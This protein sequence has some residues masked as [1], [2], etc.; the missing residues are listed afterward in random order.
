MT[1]VLVEHH[2]PQ[3]GAPAVLEETDR[4]FSCAYCRVSS[5]L[6]EADYF[7]YMLPHAAPADKPIV[8]FP[9]W[10]CRGMLFS[11]GAD[12]VRHRVVDHSRPAVSAAH[13][14][15]SLG[16]RPQTMTLKPAAALG[17]AGFLAP[18]V[19]PAAAMVDFEKHFRAAQ[20]EKTA[21]VQ[22]LVGAPLCMIYAPFYMDG[23][24]TDAVLNRPVTPGGQAAADIAGIPAAT[25]DWPIRFIPTLCPNCGW[26]M[27]AEK[28]ALSLAC[29]RCRSVWRAGIDG[30]RRMK[31]MTLPDDEKT[32]SAGRL[33]LPFWRI[34]AAVSDIA[35]ASYADFAREAN[36]PKVVQREWADIRFHFWTPALKLSPRAFLR[37]ACAMT[38]AQPGEYAADD[39]PD[40]RFYAVK[41]PLAGAVSAVKIIMAELLRP[42][43]RILPRLE[44]M[45]VSIRD[46]A[47]VYAPFHESPHEYVNDRYRLSI[48][49]NMLKLIQGT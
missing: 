37:A 32:A 10:R 29:T 1:P 21:Y 7:R 22:A 8:Y 41:L 31:C 25:A 26:D 43:N 12:A 28:D 23:T 13:F 39:I 24:L 33:Y 14:P 17:G 42:K 11:C 18:T 38:I 35:L 47:L 48:N 5:Y 44:S 19:T 9:Y 20:P 30:L 34:D 16:L 36:L 40:G 2:C 15:E 45:K 3:C 6:L 4:L 46:A 27:A 49:K